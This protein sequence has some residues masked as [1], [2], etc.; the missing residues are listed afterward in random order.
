MNATNSISSI[1]NM[2][3]RVACV[4]GVVTMCISSCAQVAQQTIQAVD[5][6]RWAT[7][8]SRSGWIIKYP[9]DFR[10]SSCRQCADP[11]APDVFVAFSKSDHVLAMV[12]P[13]ADAP[14]GQDTRKWLREVARD[15][16]LSPVL[17]EQWKSVDNESALMVTNG[18]SESDQ[19]QNV[20][21]VHRGKTFAIRFPDVKDVG[22]RLVCE[23]MLS[24]FRFSPN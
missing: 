1:P 20:Y 17:K 9:P 23:Q 8:T 6:T 2:L 5:V 16:I 12:E 21:V 10:V 24:T 18:V 7:L 19:S 15:T 4:A 11:T 14:A 13:L 22:V 3:V